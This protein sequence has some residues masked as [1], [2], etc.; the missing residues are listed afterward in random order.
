MSIDAPALRQALSL[1]PGA[2]PEG[3]ETVHTLLCRREAGAFQRAAKETGLQ[4]EELLVACTQEQTLF[5]ELN[6]QTE[7][8]A[9]VTERPIRFVNIRET[10]GWSRAA[11]QGRGLSGFMAR[12]A[13][14]AVTPKNRRPDR[15]GPIASP[16][17]RAHGDLPLGRSLPDH[18]ECARHPSCRQDAGR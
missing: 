12:P 11:P 17:G 9:S 4:G 15:C 16:A 8:S 2:S 13:E 7:G 10:A 18:W 6:A 1:T 14:Q 5:L 3:L